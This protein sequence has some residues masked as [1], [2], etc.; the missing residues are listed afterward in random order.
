MME[1]KV[2]EKQELWKREVQ[3]DALF[4]IVTGEKRSTDELALRIIA[5]ARRTVSRVR[6]SDHEHKRQCS[7][8]ISFVKN[9]RHQHYEINCKKPGIQ[10]D[11]E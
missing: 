7:L 2:N 5:R 9:A 1:S 11:K 10:V 3:G 4:E 6:D 8:A